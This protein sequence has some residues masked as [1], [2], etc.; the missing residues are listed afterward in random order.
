MGENCARPR[1]ANS[2]GRWSTAPAP[3]R[4]RAA[5]RLTVE[6]EE[7]GSFDLIVSCGA[8]ADSYD[9]SYVERRRAGE[10]AAMPQALNDVKM[11]VRAGSA[12]LKVTSS[13]RRGEADELVTFA[14]GTVPAALIDAFAAAGNHSMM[15]ETKS[16]PH[17]HRHPARQYRR[18]AEPAAADRG[19]RQAARRPRRRSAAR[20]A[21]VAAK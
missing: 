9:V 16:R 7:I 15:I 3:P 1:S 13:E 14:A 6:G 8:A 11:T 2:A 4:W 10:R 21:A 17:R 5:I 20:K 18:A 19:L 12:T